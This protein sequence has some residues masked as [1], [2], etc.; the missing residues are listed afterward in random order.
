[1]T[2]AAF[3]LGTSCGWAIRR[4]GGA[5]ESGSASF[6]PAHERD[7]ARFLKFRAFLTAMKAR[8]DAAGEA[9]GLVLYERVDFLVPGQ[10]Y[11][12]HVWGGN[13]AILTAWCEY[14]GVAYR[15]VAVTTVKKAVAGSGRADKRAVQA[16]LKARGF[17]PATSDEA[18]ALAVLLT[19]APELAA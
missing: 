14:H 9:L 16:A 15:G 5:I 12:A 18:D 17:H 2:V 1:M 10:V 8:L 4:A 7:G 3:D 19:A 13:W 6:A 11:A